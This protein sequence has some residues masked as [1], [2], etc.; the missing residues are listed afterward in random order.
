MEKKETQHILPYLRKESCRYMSKALHWWRKKR[1]SQ[2]NRD[3]SGRKCRG[4]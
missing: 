1:P 3:L 4:I 2:G